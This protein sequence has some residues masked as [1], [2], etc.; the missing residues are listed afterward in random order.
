MVDRDRGAHEGWCLSASFSDVASEDDMRRSLIRACISTRY[1]P[2]AIAD[3]GCH[4]Y[5][6]RA[7]EQ[8]RAAEALGC[9]FSGPRWTTDYDAHHGWCAQ[10]PESALHAEDSGRFAQLLE[11]TN[12]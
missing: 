2:G 5:A 12:S 11:S 10:Q 6:Q 4:T 7:A 8:A 9:G 1:A 3:M